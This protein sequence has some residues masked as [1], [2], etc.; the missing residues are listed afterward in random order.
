M[1][2][3][4]T[5]PVTIAHEAD[6]RIKELGMQREVDMMLEH[7]RQAIPDL[8]AL[9]VDVWHDMTQPG[10]AHVEMIGWRAGASKSLDDYLP[11]TEWG[12]WFVRTFP[13][14]VCLWFSFTLLYRDEHGR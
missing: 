4:A 7:T 14:R 9:E 12:T 3:P 5:I 2:A 1:A 8:E 10:E 6:E 11:Q 13:P